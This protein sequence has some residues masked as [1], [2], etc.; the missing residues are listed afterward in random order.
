MD[1]CKSI[2]LSFCFSA[3]FAAIGY[4]LAAELRSFCLSRGCESILFTSDGGLIVLFLL[5]IQV[6]AIVGI[7]LGKVICGQ[8]RARS[9]GHVL[10]AVMLGLIGS[11]ICLLL[12]AKSGLA[13]GKY[14]VHIAFTTIAVASSLG[15]ET[16]E[17]MKR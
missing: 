10:L 17:W 12:V 14:E 6:A 15:Y 4:F 16:V 9:A 13:S 5:C 1:R 11:V 3:S 8:T 2:G 7:V